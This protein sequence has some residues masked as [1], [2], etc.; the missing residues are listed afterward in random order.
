MIMR[1]YEQKQLHNRNVLEEHY[2]K[3]YSRIP[4]YRYIYRYW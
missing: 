3:V 1:D 2:Q 4:E